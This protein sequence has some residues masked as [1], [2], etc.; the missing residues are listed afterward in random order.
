MTAPDTLAGQP[1][2]RE[3]KK[4]ATRAQI[5]A[6]ADRLFLERGFDEV[7]LDQVA[8]ECEISVR[9]VLRHFETK[10]SL[11]LSDEID[12]LER[13]CVG[14]AKRRG[15]ALD[16][17][18]YYIGMVSAE[19]AARSGGS[20]DWLRR[21]F[22]MILQPPLFDG[23]LRIQREFQDVLAKALG[24]DAGDMEGDGQLTAQLLAAALIA[25]NQAVLAATVHDRLPFDPD[26]LL[27]VIDYTCE[28][29]AGYL[30]STTGRRSR[31]PQKA[32]RPGTTRSPR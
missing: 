12:Y 2:L 21:H 14:I 11:A 8:A 24:E 3:R 18:R 10:E 22:R 29:F 15:G 28:I 26:R 7:T 5:A 1:S 16:Y 4:A 23:F 17:W 25:G 27:N 20:S 30:P 9:T 6:A 13:F 32:R 31:G 19:F